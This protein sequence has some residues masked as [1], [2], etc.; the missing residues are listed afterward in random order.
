MLKGFQIKYTLK[1]WAAL[2]DLS[3]EK[4]E[5]DI[6]CFGFFLKK[7]WNMELISLKHMPITDCS[8]LHS[9]LMFRFSIQ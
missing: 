2:E 4:F 8:E 5:A 6:F 1:M 7:I 9:I 3:E